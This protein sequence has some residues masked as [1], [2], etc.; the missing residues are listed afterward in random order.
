[1]GQQS[2]G[3]YNQLIQQNRNFKNLLL[4]QSASVLGDWFN[5]IAQL[6]L[7]YGITQSPLYVSLTFLSKGVPQLLI[8]PFAGLL[9]D[10]LDRKKIM[11]TADVLRALFILGLLFAEQFIWIVFIVNFFTSITSVFFS[12]ARQ[13]V[14]KDVVD[15]EDLYLA[16]SLSSTVGGII[17]IMGASLGGLVSGMF[18]SHIAF[19]INSASF[20]I[21]AYFIQ[22]T[23]IPKHD[24]MEKKL[25]FIEDL[26]DGYRFIYQTPII[27]GVILVGISWGLI[28]GV[29]QILLTVYG[30]TV[31]HAGDMG[32]GILYATQGIGTIIGGW[33]VSRFVGNHKEKMV[34]CFGIAYLFQGIFF[35]LFASSSVFIIGI[36]FLLFMRIAGGIII[37]LDTTLIQMNTPNDKIGKV[38]SLHYSLFGALIQLSMFF[39][40]ILLEFIPPN[41]IG[42]SFGLICIVVSLIWLLMFKRLTKSISNSTSLIAIKHLNK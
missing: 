32:I 29:Y 41:I 28:G 42:T 22:A 39:A 13:G 15:E 11:V 5:M 27:L 25:S 7:V 38:F 6:G 20:L 26:K 30:E 16:N 36:T 34:L 18:S 3:S 23:T 2:K 37:P 8:S 4:G 35:T 1:M 17:S 21:S 14:I 12:S 31:Y 9:V 24:V 19:I 10:K 40:G 33:V